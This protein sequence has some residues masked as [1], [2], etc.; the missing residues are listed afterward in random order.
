MPEY[1]IV[2]IYRRAKNRTPLAGI[3]EDPLSGLQYSFHSAAELWSVL[4]DSPKIANGEDKA[5]EEG[6]ETR[7]Q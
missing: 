6:T 3:V 1:Y 2:R 4:S 7:N 5:D